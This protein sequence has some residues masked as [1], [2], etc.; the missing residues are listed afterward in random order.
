MQFV[1]NLSRGTRISARQREEAF[2]SK[3]APR[4][5]AR[6]RTARR[7]HVAARKAPT[8]KPA[9][10]DPRSARGRI[11]HR[12]C[13]VDFN[14]SDATPDAELPASTIHDEALVVHAPPRVEARAVLDAVCDSAVDTQRDEIRGSRL[15]VAVVRW[16]PH[17]LLPQPELR[18]HDIGQPAHLIPGAAE[19]S[20]IPGRGDA[21]RLK[22]PRS[23][24]QVIRYAR[25]QLAAHQS[26]A[27]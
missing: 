12:C 27:G 23:H 10:P 24:C 17:H 16:P 5:A 3:K 21:V 2:M 1:R 19:Q 8:M 22:V 6:A 13:D 14:E 15:S 11:T 9:L 20:R 25:S 26:A 7:K 4:S 18:G